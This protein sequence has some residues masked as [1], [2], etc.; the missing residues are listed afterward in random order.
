MTDLADEIDNLRDQIAQQQ[1]EYDLLQEQKEKELA[2]L[3]NLMEKRIA[4]VESEWKEKMKIEADD[5]NNQLRVMAKE[6]DKLRN[7]FSGDSGGWVLKKNKKGVQFYENLETGEVQEKMPEVLFISN[8]MLKIEE[9]EKQLAEM[10]SLKERCKEAELKKREADILANKVK[11]EVNA[12]RL[13]EK[14]WIVSAKDVFIATRDLTKHINNDIDTIEDRIET[15]NKSSIKLHKK[16]GSINRVTVILKKLQLTVASQ[17]EEIKNLTT[18]NQKLVSDLQI[19]SA[20]LDRIMRN[21]EEEVERQ[22]KPMRDQVAE[23]VVLLMKEKASRA[24]ERR[25]IADLWPPGHLMPTLLMKSRPISEEERIRRLKRSKDLEASRALT[26]E[27]RA[28]VIE[29]TKWVTKYDDYGRLYYE[30]SDTGESSWEPPDIMSYEPPPGRDK[31]GNLIIPPEKLDSHWKLKTDY[32]GQVYYYHEITQEMTYEP[33]DAYRKIPPGKTSEVIVSEA[34]QLVLAYVRSKIQAKMDKLAAERASASLEEERSTGGGSAS[35]YTH[36]VGASVKNQNEA[37]AA[38][39]AASVAQGSASPQEPEEDLSRYL[40][41]IE[42]IEMIA[43][44]GPG[45]VDSAAAREAKEKERSGADR[46]QSTVGTTLNSSMASSMVGS[47]GQTAGPDGSTLFSQ[48]SVN[49]DTDGDGSVN[50]AES[51]DGGDDLARFCGPSIC[52]VDHEN[53]IPD[54]VRELL[55]DLALAEDRLERKLGKVRVNLKVQLFMNLYLNMYISV[56]ECNRYTLYFY[57]CS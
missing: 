48:H 29:A 55:Q 53:M 51:K 42:T 57:S 12:L 5:F 2:E 33:P 47:V 34:A 17:E 54:Q 39:S 56:D 31:M 30:H 44:G 27:I 19:T 16:N 10:I 9:A 26:L 13:L 41:D 35:A 28:N 8:A 20:K 24:Q 40:Y 6:L 25:N 43:N 7:A 3:E 18:K 11:T 4:D 32:K 50:D 22:V 49:E 14:G 37:T 45:A 52:D 1:R 38:G 15:I 23:T 36:S 46:K 21:I